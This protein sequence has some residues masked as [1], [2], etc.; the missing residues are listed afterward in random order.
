MFFIVQFD[1][2]P[3]V[4]SSSD[5]APRARDGKVALVAYGTGMLHA[6]AAWA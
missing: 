3:D 6:F 4:I 5:T 1:M 2:K